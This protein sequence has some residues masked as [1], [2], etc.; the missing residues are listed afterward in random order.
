MCLFVDLNK[1]KIKTCQ[2][3]QRNMRNKPH[4]VR[5]SLMVLRSQGTKVSCANKQYIW[6][7]RSCQRLGSI[8]WE[9]REAF[10]STGAVRELEVLRGRLGKPHDSGEYI[11]ALICILKTLLVYMRAEEIL[12]DRLVW[13]PWL[14][15]LSSSGCVT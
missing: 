3:H 1:R 4:I 5:I 10:E 2:M 14:R 11:T 7:Y 6:G 9:V 8:A 15:A 13:I 12:R